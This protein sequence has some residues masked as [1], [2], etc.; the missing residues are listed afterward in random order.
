MKY[1]PYIGVL[2]PKRFTADKQ[3]I[4]YMPPLSVGILV[5]KEDNPC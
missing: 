3:N 5:G 4:A 1:L 2:L